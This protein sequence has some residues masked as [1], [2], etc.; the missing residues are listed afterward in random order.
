MPHDDAL[1]ITLTVANHAVH[2]VLIDNGSSA[3]IIYWTVVQQLGI[4]QEKLKPFLSLLTGFAAYN[5][6]IGHPALN[7][8][9][10]VTSTYHLKVK[11]PTIEGVGEVKG[12]QVVARRCYHTSLK[13]CPKSALLMIGSL[14]DERK[15]QLRKE[16]AKPL[17]DVPIAEGKVV[18]IGSQLTPKVREALVRFLQ[19]NLKVF[20]WSPEDMPRIDPKDI[21]HHLNINLEVK[22]VKQK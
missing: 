19:Q 13:K 14:G 9:R 12:D 2:R 5:M 1:V 10:E 7:H 22:P 17:I 16:L 18:K 8:L 20:A 4:G 21:V 3:D 11:F 15:L 6:I